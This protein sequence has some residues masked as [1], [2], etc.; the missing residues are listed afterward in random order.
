MKKLFFV[1]A[2]VFYTLFSV[3]AQSSNSN[4]I[5]DYLTKNPSC[6]SGALTDYSGYIILSG[7][8]TAAWSGIPQSLIDYLNNEYYAGRTVDDV[9]LT[10]RGNW[11]CVGDKLYGQGYP[12]S[13]WTKMDDFLCQGDRINCITFNYYGEWIIITDKHFCASDNSIQDLMMEASKS[14]GFIHTAS[15]NNSGLIIVGND[16]FKSRW[17]IPDSLDKYLRYDQSFYI[18]YIKFTE[19]GSWLVTDGYSRYCYSLY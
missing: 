4:F 2:F 1:L 8:N 10:E 14:Y 6:K 13:M 16:G 7:K 19:K 11:F 9:C 12:Q 15:M 3:F 18:K 17:Y 5:H